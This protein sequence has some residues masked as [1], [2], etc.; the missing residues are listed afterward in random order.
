MNRH[1]PI[2]PFVLTLL[3]VG[4]FSLMDA[5]VKNA[6]LVIGVYSTLLWRSLTAV[7]LVVPAWRV[8]GWRWP[9]AATLRLHVTRGVVSTGTSLTFFWGLERLPLAEA[10][11]I[12]FLAPLIALYLAAVILG[13][14][15]GRGAVAG[16]LLGLSGVAMIA[17]MRMGEGGQGDGAFEG[18]LSVLASAMLY[19]WNLI[20]TRQQAQLASPLEVASFTNCVVALMLLPLAPLLAVVPETAYVA[21]NIGGSAILAL[22]GGMLFSWAY[23][24]A[25]AQALVPVEYSA[26]VW[27]ALFGWLFFAEALEVETVAG[28]ALIVAGCWIA[29]P[30]RRPEVSSL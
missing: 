12:S 4:L 27:A 6:T 13:E 2:M 14:R 15:I 8:S 25:E 5:L 17:V 20:L 11:A 10:I 26:F 3:A 28:A 23:A 22:V 21:A 7:L 24:R 19:A 18:I 16:S 1:A 30:R 29:A 9:P